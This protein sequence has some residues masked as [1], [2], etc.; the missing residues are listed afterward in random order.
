MLMVLAGTP[1]TGFLKT[2]L[3]I[4]KITVLSCPL[5]ALVRVLIRIA[6]AS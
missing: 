1:K 4:G 2:L 6:S 3:I 5:K